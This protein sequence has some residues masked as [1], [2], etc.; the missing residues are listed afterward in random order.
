[1]C[2]FYVMIYDIQELVRLNILEI[3][4]LAI[5]LTIQ[6]DM[7]KRYQNQQIF[8]QSNISH[9]RKMKSY[10]CIQ[11]RRLE[12]RSLGVNASEFTLISRPIS[13]RIGEIRQP[14][15][16]RYFVNNIW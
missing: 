12:A 10:V 9:K 3:I 6:N 14:I 15:T 4:M 16:N 2:N 13:A 7:R 5:H 8:I 11:T 1:M